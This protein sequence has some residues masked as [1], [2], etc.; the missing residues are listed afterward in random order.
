MIHILVFKP[1]NGKGYTLKGSKIS[2]MTY[3]KKR[4]SIEN[5]KV[6]STFIVKIRNDDKNG[7]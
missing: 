6:D 7:N 3:Y 4:N 1:E 5:I 2:S